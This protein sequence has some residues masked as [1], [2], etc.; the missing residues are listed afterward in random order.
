MPSANVTLDC[1][2]SVAVRV[3]SIAMSSTV[4]LA[5]TAIAGGSL[6]SVNVITNVN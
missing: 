5:V 3:I 6:I 2:S 1:S 4:E